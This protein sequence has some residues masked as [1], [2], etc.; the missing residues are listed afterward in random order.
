MMLLGLLLSL[1]A[2]APAQVGPAPSAQ[3]EPGAVDELFKR[4]TSGRP[5]IP[6]LK[7]VQAEQLKRDLALRPEAKDPGEGP[8]T[9]FAQRNR[10]PLTNIRRQTDES[11]DVAVSRPLPRLEL[12]VGYS[13]TNVYQ[14]QRRVQDTTRKYA[15]LSVDLSRFPLRRKFLHSPTAVHAESE[16]GEKIRVEKDEYTTRFL[17]HPNGD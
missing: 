8:S 15:F 4:F 7:E 5:M 13:E 11:V 17:K 1:A 6:T 14:G 9:S 16:V 3:V 2:P 12:G 10:P